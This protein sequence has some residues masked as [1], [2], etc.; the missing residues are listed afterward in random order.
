MENILLQKWL[1]FLQKIASKCKMGAA[2][3][4]SCLFDD[5][6]SNADLYP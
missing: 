5:Y 6:G 4:S 3:I 2:G 1:K